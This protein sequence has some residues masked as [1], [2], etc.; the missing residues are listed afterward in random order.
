MHSRHENSRIMMTRSKTLPLRTRLREQ[1]NCP[2]SLENFDKNTTIFVHGGIK[3][4]AFQLQR[5]LIVV[6]NATN[7]ITRQVFSI[8]ELNQLDKACSNGIKVLKGEHA[9]AAAEMIQEDDNNLIYLENELQN[10]L[11]KF[12]IH[13]GHQ[14]NYNLLINEVNEIRNDVCRVSTHDW[15]EMVV[16]ADV[17]CEVYPAYILS[18]RFEIL[19]IL[20][21][22]QYSNNPSYISPV[23]NMNTIDSGASSSSG[24]S[25]D[26]QDSIHETYDSAAMLVPAYSPYSDRFAEL[27]TPPPVQRH[28]N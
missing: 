12:L 2:I 27:R 22:P 13:F 16:R 17:F 23:N 11:H 3:F 19:D 24:S 26:S 4:N 20:D 25:S 21:P 7:P 9:R 15:E 8:S 28:N 10:S 1:T 18:T 6:P 14:I 5:Y